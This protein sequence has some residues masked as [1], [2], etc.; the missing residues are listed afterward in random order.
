MDNILPLI[1]LLVL[2][3]SLSLVT[4]IIGKEVI[5]KR[6]IELQLAELQNK[7]R[8][9]ECTYE[10]YYDLGKIYLSKKLFD[11]AIIQ[12]RY[13]LKLWDLEDTEGLANLYNTVG[14]TYAET[15]QYEIAIF[16]YQEAIKYIKNYIAA[17]N[18]LGFA[19][20]KK[21]LINE[22]LRIYEEVINYDSENEVATN[23]I[24]VLNRRLRISG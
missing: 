20:E 14:F 24:L 9:K 22:A 2:L 8:T 15:E 18:N 21:Q 4:I 1:Y 10:D 13:A 17:L 6:Q 3:T 19:Y 16:Y 11:Q 12:F 7:I 5:K 23:R